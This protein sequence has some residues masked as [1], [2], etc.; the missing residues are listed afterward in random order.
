MTKMA[1]ITKQ[2]QQSDPINVKQTDNKP[3]RITQ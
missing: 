3:V 2:T 1:C